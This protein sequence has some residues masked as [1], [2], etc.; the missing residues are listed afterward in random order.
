ML[1]GMTAAPVTHQATSGP[2]APVGPTPHRLVRHALPVGVV[3]LGLAVV[4]DRLPSIARAASP[5]E[6]G[7]LLIGSQWGPGTS[8]YGNYWVDR[9]PLLIGIFGAAAH[10][11]GVVPLRVFGILDVVLSIALSAILTRSVTSSKG[12][13][14]WVPTMVAATLLSSPL[15]D[16]REVNGELLA[17][18]FVLLGVLGVV[19][20]VQ[21][22]DGRRSLA[23]GLLGGASGLAAACVK[24]NVVDVFVFTGALA[25]VL[26]LSRPGRAHLRSLWS[27]CVGAFVALAAMVAIAVMRGTSLS[28]L[29]YALIGFRLDAAA[30]IHASATSATPVRLRT[31]LGALAISGAPLIAIAAGGVLVRSPIRP[32][33]RAG[34][35]QQPPDLRVPALAMLAWELVA[36]LL[37]GSYW[38]HYLVG[39]IPGVVVLVVAAA[40]RPWS[41]R[42]RLAFASGVGW[43]GIASA[44]GLV[45]VLTAPP[46]GMGSDGPIVSYLRAHERP[47]DT[48]VVAFGHPDVLW[49]TGLTSPYSELWSLPVRVRDPHLSAL[50]SV[51]ESPQ[52]PTWVVVDGTSL[53]TWGVDPT[54]AERTLLEHY[55]KVTDV[56]PYTVYL[57]EGV[58][59]T[60]GTGSQ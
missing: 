23:W 30:A 36:V 49:S 35:R 34:G 19:R 48:A 14:V 20:C 25:I 18:P 47:G 3:V 11:G 60:A 29:G 17:V 8:L 54:I 51:L 21:G 22:V 15:F 1:A 55:D 13:R 24:Q 37:G 38:L 42:Q 40:Q 27:V 9:P 28:E 53:Y 57:R 5:D 43:T 50:D 16:T 59:R 44:I 33:D 10:L 7:F 31:L 56:S 45:A 39:L 6:G 4:L 26:A 2:P 52:R 12:A 46:H 32:A 41:R 58:D